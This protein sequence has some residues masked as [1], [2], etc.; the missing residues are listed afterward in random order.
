MRGHALASTRLGIGA[1]DA[2]IAFLD[3]AAARWHNPRAVWPFR[4]KSRI[5]ADDLFSKWFRPQV[6]EGYPSL[7]AFETA[8]T[9]EET[10][11]L[12]KTLA[13][14]AMDGV[15]RIFQVRK[16]D[17]DPDREGLVF[18]DGLLNA[19]MRWKLTEGQDPTY[20]RNLFRVVATEFGCIVG[21]IWVRTGR[22]AWAPRRAPNHWRSA[23][24][25]P[26]GEEYDPFRAV[27]RKMSDERRDA[28]LAAAYDAAR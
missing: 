23:V 22:G 6:P 10:E 9:D 12:P 5:R 20:P 15:E 17:L 13:K 7:E 4:R 3:V 19:E 21:E 27:V 8:I 11:L 18:L 16:H 14:L 26:G 24:R 2:A 1:D 28:G 25:R